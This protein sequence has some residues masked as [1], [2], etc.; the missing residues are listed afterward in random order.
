VDEIHDVI[1]ITSENGLLHPQEGVVNGHLG[2]DEKLRHEKIL[3]LRMGVVLP[4]TTT[5]LKVPSDKGYTVAD[6]ITG[7]GVAES[8]RHYYELSGRSIKGKKAIIQGWG[9]V[10]AAAGYYLSKCG[11]SIIG[12]I[13]RDGGVLNPEGYSHH[14]VCQLFTGRDGNRLISPD[15][16]PF[17]EIN[18]VIWDSGAHIFIPAA[19]S[20]LVT[21]DQV[22]RMVAKGLEAISCGA[23][24]PFA[25]QEIF[26]GPTTAHADSKLTLI[27]DFISNCGMARVFAYLITEDG[28]IT[29]EAIFEDVS[30]VIRDSIESIKSRSSLH[31]GITATAFNIA[32]DKLSN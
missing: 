13:D 29:D 22:D 14:E 31:T 20:R 11:A 7:F 3:R 9:N 23:N 25:D 30:Y 2:T 10:G 8:I 21:R 1:A 27:P 24:V 26:Y 6:M 32:L 19:A 28:D 4:V 16:I 15:M 5:G 12:I 18:N 17:D